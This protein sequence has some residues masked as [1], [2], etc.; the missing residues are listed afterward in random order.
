[1]ATLIA[2]ALAMISTRQAA[3]HTVPM[4]TLQADIALPKKD[5]GAH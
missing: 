3:S 4:E 2:V 5:S 1:M